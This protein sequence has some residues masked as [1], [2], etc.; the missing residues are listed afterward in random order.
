MLHPRDPQKL[1]QA[2]RTFEE[3]L[4]RVRRAQRVSHGRNRMAC[5]ECSDLLNP[6]V[7]K[8]ITPDEQ[9]PGSCLDQ[10]REGGIDFAV[11][12]CFQYLNL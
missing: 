11:G 9:P 10:A 3:M 8:E 7:E 4:D 12:A 1:A 5:R 6:V 2:K